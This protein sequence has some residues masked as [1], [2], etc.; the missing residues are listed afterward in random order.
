MQAQQCKQARAGCS[1]AG[2]KHCS[3]GNKFFIAYQMSCSCRCRWDFDLVGQFETPL[4]QRSEAAI[5]TQ[6]LWP[7]HAHSMGLSRD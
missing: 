1:W 3:R 2:H 4:R 5:K 7:G 6:S